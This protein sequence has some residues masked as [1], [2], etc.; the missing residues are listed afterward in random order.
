MTT[1][2]NDVTLPANPTHTNM[3]SPERSEL[4]QLRMRMKH[5]RVATLSNVDQHGVL[6]SETLQRWEMDDSGALWFFTDRCSSANEHLHAFN[7]SFSD[8]AH[9]KHISLSG[10]AEI[11]AENLGSEPL[12]GSIWIGDICISRSSMDN[13][14]TLLRFIPQ[15]PVY[16]QAPQ[17]LLT[18]LLARLS[19]FTSVVACIGRGNR[20][21]AQRPS[22]S[23]NAAESA[24]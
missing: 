8:A 10:H 12:L 6:L 7:L 16:W 17:S 13:R 11:Q 20:A 19:A 21:T 18:R 23:L 9:S 22:K 24:S 4:A 14:G 2:T 3:P 1:A 5:M 15:T